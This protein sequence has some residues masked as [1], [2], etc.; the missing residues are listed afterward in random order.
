MCGSRLERGSQCSKGKVKMCLPTGNNPK[1]AELGPGFAFGKSSNKGWT[2]FDSYLPWVVAASLD[3]PTQLC[4]LS[5]VRC[6]CPQ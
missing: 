4:R 5:F 3:Q 1:A 6:C 2:L